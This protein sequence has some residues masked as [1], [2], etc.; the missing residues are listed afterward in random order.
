MLSKIAQRMKMIHDARYRNFYFQ[1]MVTDI[2]TRERKAEALAARL[3][4]FQTVQARDIEERAAIL[5]QD[6]FVMM[7]NVVPSTW[8]NDMRSYFSETPCS[9]PYR[10]Q[11]GSFLAPSG[12]PK[13]T[14][15]AFFGNEAVT[16]APHA[17]EIANHPSILGV[18]ARFLGSKPTISYITA[19]WSVP[20][21]DGTAQHAE[22]YHRD[23]DDWRFVKFFIYLTDV[24]DTAGPHRFVRGSHRINRLTPIRRYTDEEVHAAFGAENEVSFT[25]KAGTCFL[26]NTYGMHRGYPPKS[27]PR[28]IFQVLFSQREVIYG[29]KRSLVRIGEGAPSGID[30][31]VN[32]VYCSAA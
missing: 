11:L 32:R 2:P 21:G 27:T 8:V 30:P 24:D 20:A 25:G 9:D 5:D 15:V 14:H 22:N 29:P 16:A 1:R 12:A 28:L 19:W 7:E 13:G 26:E 4:A 6:G 17:F 18:A 3:P 10:P 31:Y 23:V